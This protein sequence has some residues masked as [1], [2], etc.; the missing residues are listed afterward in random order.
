MR[1]SIDAFI[2]DLDG[3]VVDTTDYHFVAWRRLANELGFDFDETRNE[4]LKGIGR[5][6][7][8]ARILKWGGIEMDEAKRVEVATKKNNWYKELIAEMNSEEILPGVEAFIHEAKKHD[9]KIALGSASK[10]A[11]FILERLGLIPLFDAIVDGNKTTRS[12]PDPQVF[13]LA[14]IELNVDPSR[15]IVF[16]DAKGGIEAALRGGFYAVGVGDP[17]ILSKA[18]LVVPSFTGITPDT[19]IQTVVSKNQ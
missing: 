3:L 10:N 12:K 6:E 11:P 16:E 9:I 4:E 18:H 15:A 2:F 17:Q 7:S 8:L 13:N 5:M 14:A 19:V 1:N